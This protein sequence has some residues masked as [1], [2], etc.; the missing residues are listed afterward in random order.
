VFGELC[1]I[2]NHDY[3]NHKS[4]WLCRCSCGN[5][6]VVLGRDLIKGH[7]RSCGCY[8]SKTTSERC[9][10]RLIDRKFGRLLVIEELLERRNGH[11]YWKCLCDCGNY[12]EVSSGDLN[13][14]KCVSCGCYRFD[15][16]WKGGISAEPYCPIWLDEDYKKS[17]KERDNYKCQNPYCWGTHSKLFLHHINYNKQ[18]CG[19]QNLITLCCSCNSRANINRDYW[20]NLYEGIMRNRGLLNDRSSSHN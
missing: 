7:T 11:V 15:I 1:V 5:T 10:A 2:K 17:I 19:P 20:Q 18:E 3:F 9:K 16:N 12:S 8:K 6:V 13:S 14:G 4:R